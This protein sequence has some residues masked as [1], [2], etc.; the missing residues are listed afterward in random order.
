MKVAIIPARSGSKRIKNKN[1][2]LF[3]GKP[4]L[5]Y[6][7]QAAKKSKIFDKI[8]ISTESKK[9]ANI[10]LKYGA[11]MWIKRPKKLADDF[12][13]TFEVLKHA[14]DYLEMNKFKIKYFCCINPN[15]FLK[16]DNLIKSHKIF[17]R[18]K[19][20]CMLSVTTYNYPI[21]RSLKLNKKNNLKFIFPKFS[22][23]RS[24][25]LFATYHDAG[26]FYCPIMMLDNSIGGKKRNSIKLK[27]VDTDIILIEFHIY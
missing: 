16:K 21:F 8:I 17:L 22:L 1:I 14:I 24:Q 6:S 15:P 26:Q 18:K 23:K 25:D 12:T 10:A 5:S 27:I 2:K 13:S 3:Y 20:S 11:S 7:I 9:I 19:P 4:L